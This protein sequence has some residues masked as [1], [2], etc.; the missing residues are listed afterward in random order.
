MRLMCIIILYLACQV[1]YSQV[2]EYRPLAGTMMTTI[3]VPDAQF[4]ESTLRRMSM[5][6]I[7]KDDLR[8]RNVWFFRSRSDE[9]TYFNAHPSLARPYDGWLKAYKSLQELFLFPVAEL[10]TMGDSAVLLI[11]DRQG[12]ITSQVLQGDDPRML[13]INGIRV[14]L[15]YFNT[16]GPG[17]PE[18]EPW[19]Q[20]YAAADGELSEPLAREALLNLAARVPYKT[21]YLEMRAD[22]WFINEHGYPVM[23]AFEESQPPARDQFID[24]KTVVCRHWGNDT[25]CITIRRQE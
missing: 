1:L 2:P 13:I 3:T 11:R 9:G 5:D 21:V 20:M 8:L 4:S 23:P 22:V 14:R 16:A 17:R 12:R 10:I 19:L 6:L 15:L 24:S 18:T 25:S 7:R